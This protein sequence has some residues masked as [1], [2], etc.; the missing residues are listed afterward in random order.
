M[1]SFRL[2]L[3]LLILA[4]PVVARAADSGVEGYTLGPQDRLMIRVHTLRKN[5]GEIYPWAALN[6]EF[7]VG[8]NGSVSM[9]I[10]GEIPAAG[11]ST[12][13]LAHVISEALKQKA[14]LAET[15]STSVEV[16]KY[17]PYFVTGAVQQPGRF[18]YQP[19]LTVLQAVSTAQG[20]SRAADLTGAD[21]EIIAAGG[22][23][24]VLDA[25]RI[26][27]EAKVA[28]LTAEVSEAANVTYPSKL[29]ERSSDPRIAR[30]MREEILRFE[31]RREALKSEVEAIERSKI[32][33]RQELAALEVK[34]KS[35]DQLATITQREV[36]SVNELLSKGL[37][38][39]PRALS[40]ESNRVMLESNRL[41]VQAATLRAQQS[42][43]RA[44]RDVVEIRTKY[45]R[46]ALDDMATARS[47]LD[48]NAEKAQTSE[49]LL[50][51]AKLRANAFGDGIDD[52]IPVYEL[53]RLTPSGPVT[54]TAAENEAVKAGDVLRVML[55][56]P[57]RR[58]SSAS[59][60]G[61]PASPPQAEAQLTVQP[62]LPKRSERSK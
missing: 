41:D 53:T 56:Y 25:E 51:N 38:V 45:R 23:L 58:K 6:G 62:P 8:A 19:S 55:V 36:Q 54:W 49:R 13:E 1:V 21:R 11:R 18:D 52:P 7:S 26:A 31:A 5:A 12:A 44:D 34:A 59:A 50:Q 20:I 14:D 47:L 17:R 15:P 33:L 43:A 48:Q 40:A 32:L 57:N 9:P 2:I 37:T 29:I 30:A 28:R 10:M 3:A 24:R 4:S 16:V 42:L 60:E 46:E 22:D 27:L 61:E 39:A 35:L